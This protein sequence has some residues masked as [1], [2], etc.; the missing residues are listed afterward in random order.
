VDNIIW[1]KADAFFFVFSAVA[2]AERGTVDFRQIYGNFKFLCDNVDT[3]DVVDELVS[4]G[5]LDLTYD[6]EYI[7][8]GDVNR[9]RRACFHRLVQR[10]CIKGA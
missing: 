6:L 3:R 8:K 5:V 4:Q 10:L 2:I 1:C 9:T 7:K